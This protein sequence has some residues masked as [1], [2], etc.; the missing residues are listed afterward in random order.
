MFDPTSECAFA[1][2]QKR[3]K[4]ARVK[5]T[6]ITLTIIKNVSKGVPRGKYKTELMDKKMCIKIP[7]FRNM[8]GQQVRTALLEK[9]LTVDDIVDYKLLQCSGQQLMHALDQLPSGSDII[10]SAMKRK[11]NIVYAFP[12]SKTNSKDTDSKVSLCVHGYMSFDFIL[13]II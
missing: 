13:H 12:V 5:P 7:L 10:D 11:G 9:L 3:K 1:T 8:S 2:Q 4:A 6:N